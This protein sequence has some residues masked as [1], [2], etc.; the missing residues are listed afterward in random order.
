MIL[1]ILSITF[2]IYIGLCLIFYIFQ[3]YFFFR[4]EI[5]PQ[6]FQ[7]KYPYPF[8]EKR[9]DMEDGGKI[10]A[11]HFKVPNALG[12][13]YYLKGNSKSIKGWGKFA[14]DFLGN[15]YD[16]FMIDYRGFG[17]SKGKRTESIL[18]ADA[19]FLYKKLV[20]EYQEKNIVVYGRS[21]GTGI[22]ARIA[23]WNNPNLLILDS[24][25]Y[26]FKQLITDKG[27]FLFPL[28]Y[29][30]KYKMPTNQFLKVCNCPIHI[31]HG[32]KD[33]LI[34]V[35]KHSV[36]L[37]KERSNINLVLIDGAHHNN[38][39]KFPDFHMKLYKILNLL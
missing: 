4:P 19:Q 20:H 18:Y 9:Y 36:I 7:F 21:F 38:L 11:V 6:H 26:S 32:T 14:Q 29:L 39:P 17:K 22:A 30:L 16:F 34:P 8:E 33:F 28:K 24:P 31:I 3:D 5:L 27:G 1:E 15:G 35:K 25:Y 2:A 10:N 37:K 12:V 23:S 13:V